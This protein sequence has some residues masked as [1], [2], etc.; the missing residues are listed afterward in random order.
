MNN[1]LK[2]TLVFVSFLIY[3]AFITFPFFIFGGD[4]NFLPNS[5]KITYLISYSS[6]FL[7]FIILVYKKELIK[8][9]L[10]FLINGKKYITESLRNWYL[11]LIIMILS[12][13]IITTISPIN[14]AEN[15]EK[16]RTLLGIIPLYMIFSTVLYA[17]IV[18][19][20]ICRQAIK[21]IVKEKW[22]FIIISGFIFGFAHVIGL[23]SSPWSFL[24]IIPYGALGS[25]FAY[26]FYQT[27]NLFSSIF[28]HALHNGILITLYLIVF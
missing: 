12:N 13:L 26:V 16:V 4:F 1:Y 15:E 2:T 14:I 11:G 27:K 19:E 17:P 23:A 9:Y 20:I 10:D 28:L 6:I 3:P 24:Y 5:L 22:P 8:Y 25:V 7:C 18:E 21:D